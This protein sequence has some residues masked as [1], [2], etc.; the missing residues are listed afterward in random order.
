VFVTDRSIDKIFEFTAGGSVLKTWGAPGGGR[1]QFHFV[2]RG[3]L[4]GLAVDAHGDIWV[5]DTGNNRVQELAPSGKVLTV[6]T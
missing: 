5:A 6:W 1:G 4:N 2:D 3:Y